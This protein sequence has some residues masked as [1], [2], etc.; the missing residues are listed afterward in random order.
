MATTL[1]PLQEYLHTSYRP[2][3][4]YIDGTI[5][6]RNMGQYEHARLQGLIVTAL[7]IRESEWHIHV[8]PEQRIKIREGKYR[9]PDVIV[10][11]EDAPHPRVI[12]QPPLLCIEVLSPEDR[13]GEIV[14]RAHDY[15]ALGV[16]ATWI[17]DPV[18]KRAYVYSAD[19]L[20]EMRADRPLE[21]SQGVVRVELSPADLFKQV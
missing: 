4:D 13:L 2:D 21:F 10:L 6:E 15:W 11:A 1:I 9:V 20:H 16:E 8:L 3:C 5:I 18:Q 19:G 7:M 12:E 17:F 14:D